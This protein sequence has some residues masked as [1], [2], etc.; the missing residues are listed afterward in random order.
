[1]YS[2]VLPNAGAPCGTEFRDF[3]ASPALFRCL[4]VFSRRGILL[5]GVPGIWA[6]SELGGLRVKHKS[7]PRGR[8]FCAKN[9]NR[10]GWD[11]VCRAI[12]KSLQTTVQ[13][14][15]L[16]CP[17]TDAWLTPQPSGLPCPQPGPHVRSQALTSVLEF[18]KRAPFTTGEDLREKELGEPLLAF[19]TS[20]G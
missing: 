19:V 20:K 2:P 11:C 18:S 12:A 14:A 3:A 6:E 7:H 9:Q 1:M 8:L 5:D 13:R 10:I 16:S 4:G 15:D 17:L